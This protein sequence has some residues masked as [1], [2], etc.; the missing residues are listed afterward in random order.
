M[1]RHSDSTPPLDRPLFVDSCIIIH[2]ATLS[3]GV[4]RTFKSV[5]PSVCLSVNSKTKDPKVF[6]LGVGNDLGISYKCYGFGVLRSR[7]GLGF[8]NWLNC[9]N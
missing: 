4:G 6:K 7:L 3:V 5:C 2:A 8:D 1:G 9:T